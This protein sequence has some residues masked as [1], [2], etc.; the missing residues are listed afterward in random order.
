MAGCFPRTIDL[1]KWIKQNY[2]NWFALAVAGNPE[3]QS[4]PDPVMT[5]ATAALSAT[6]GETTWISIATR[7]RT[8]RRWRGPAVLSRQ[9]KSQRT[10]PP[11]PAV[12]HATGTLLPPLTILSNRFG[13]FEMLLTDSEHPCLQKMASFSSSKPPSQKPTNHPATGRTPRQ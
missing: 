3:G 4:V 11:P 9:A 5:K 10:T 7:T 2:G 6:G 13:M 8:C 12:S 1:V